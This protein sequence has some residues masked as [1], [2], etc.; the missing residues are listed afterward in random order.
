MPIDVNGHRVGKWDNIAPRAKISLGPL[1]A[2]KDKCRATGGRGN[3]L[4]YGSSRLF[5]IEALFVRAGTACGF[6]VVL[7]TRRYR[8]T[9][10]INHGLSNGCYLAPDCPRL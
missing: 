7:R 2:R 5:F 9:V 3:C 4:D 8:L 1:E 10:I 6:Y